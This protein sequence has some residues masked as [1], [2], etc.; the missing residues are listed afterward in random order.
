MSWF[1]VHWPWV[2]LELT[3]AQIRH[4]FESVDEFVM[5][6]TFFEMMN[7]TM[8]AG[9][10]DRLVRRG[11]SVPTVG[12]RCAERQD[13]HWLGQRS[14][15][16]YMEHLRRDEFAEACQRRLEAKV[17]KKEMGHLKKEAFCRTK[18]ASRKDRRREYRTSSSS[19]SSGAQRR[20][21]HQR[22]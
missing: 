7:Q 20:G 15:R 3:E 22:H 16:E 14:A 8:N 9:S 10:S 13:P 4:H 19:S 17:E 12:N 18:K 5:D 2:D 21:H 1:N 11:K 6:F